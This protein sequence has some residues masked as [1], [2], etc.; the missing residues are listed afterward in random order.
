[1]NT[2]LAYLK[3]LFIF[4]FILLAGAAVL[5]SPLG[6]LLVAG[7]LL[8]LP[9]RKIRPYILNV[10]ESVD[11]TV[12]AVGFGNMDHTIS[13]RI[14]R[15]A[16]KGSRVALIMEKVVNALFWFDPNHCRRAIEHDE[17]EQCYLFK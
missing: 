11:Q 7:S 14:G 17:H 1:M 5:L 8:S 3:A 13:G 9:F 10:W 2:S 6:V 16:M 4:I 15:A 12:N